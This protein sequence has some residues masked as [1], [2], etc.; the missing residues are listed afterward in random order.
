VFGKFFDFIDNRHI[1]RRLLLILVAYMSFDAYQWAKELVMVK[2]TP[3][4]ELG[5]IIA[6]VTIP[7]S[8]LLKEL[9][10]LYNQSREGN[11]G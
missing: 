8:F 1:I 11:K 3:G 2:D 9:V 10:S 7:I 4:A 5:L 6:A